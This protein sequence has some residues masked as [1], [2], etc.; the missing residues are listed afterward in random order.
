MVQVIV[1]A[2]LAG[3]AATTSY[4]QAAGEPYGLDPY[5]PTDAWWLRNYGAVLVSQTPLLDL[6]KLDPYKPSDAAL[7]RELGGALPVWYGGLLPVTPDPSSTQT[8]P[9]AVTNIFVV[10]PPA[11]AT[12][13]AAPAAAP[14][15][16]MRSAIPPANNDG[17]SI[18]F[19][20]ATWIADGRAVPLEGA[21]L[22]R[23][24]EY[25]GAPVYR[26][27]TNADVIYVPSRD[28]MAAPFR[29]KQ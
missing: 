18:R 7:I 6:T 29:R 23:V 24:G 25:A 9:A 20:G 19:N 12:A 11:S 27:P 21:G 28:G 2:A 26:S 14:S 3:C 5:K 17:V 8:R 10:Q 15:V 13:S 22:E 16:P 4:A 1:T